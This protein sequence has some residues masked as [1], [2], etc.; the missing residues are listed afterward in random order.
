MADRT[1]EMVD[2]HV[3]V[4]PGRRI[5]RLSRLSDGSL[6][7]EVRARPIEGKANAATTALIAHVGGVPKSSVVLVAG[8]SARHKVVRVPKRCADRIHAVLPAV[9]FR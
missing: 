3:V 4:R 1:E 2:L 8:P 7:V 6:S 9:D 5:E